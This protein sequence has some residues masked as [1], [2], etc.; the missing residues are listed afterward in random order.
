MT[1]ST[2][3]SGTFRL[4]TDGLRDLKPAHGAG[5][6]EPPE[7]TAELRRQAAELLS[8]SRW[9]R[10]ECRRELLL[11]RRWHGVRE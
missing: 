2:N 4:D 1:H 3:P 9:W 10:D 7:E 6:V 8:R 5:A 11:R